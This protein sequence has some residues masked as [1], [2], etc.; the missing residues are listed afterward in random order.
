M[1]ELEL[2]RFKKGDIIIKNYHHSNGLSLEKNNISKTKIGSY[3]GIYDKPGETT[4][5]VEY[6]TKQTYDGDKDRKYHHYTYRL[7]EACHMYVHDSRIVDIEFDLYSDWE[8]GL[9]MKKILD[10]I[11]KQSSFLVY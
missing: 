8:R 4:Y 11:K 9:K 6:L 1:K 10:N 3:V 2:P 5:T 7:K